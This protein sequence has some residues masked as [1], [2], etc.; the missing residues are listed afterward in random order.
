MS[1]LNF[2]VLRT[3][4]LTIQLKELSL[5]ESIAVAGMPVHL[6]EAIA[7]AFLR[8]AASSVKGEQDPAKWTV[9]ERTFAVCHYLACVR[10]DGP[11]FSLGDNSKYSDYF[12]GE[13]DISQAVRLVPVGEIGGDA[14]NVRHLTG[15]MAESIERIAGLVDGI[16]GR[17][18]WMLGQMAAQLVRDGE[19]TPLPED[20]EGEFDDWLATR[21]KIMAGFPS[22]EFELMV[23]AFGEGRDKLHHL[24]R[25]HY[26]DS[27]L[28]AMPKEGA[29]AGLPPA[30]F[31]V[32]S[33][34]ASIVLQLV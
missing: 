8:T 4:R 30:R 6:N 34:L 14:W 29:A 25:M 20:G 13:S 26:D 32:R 3:K 10:D 31:P 22:S 33:G 16:G 21:M 27:G 12:D 18:H 28:L 5:G 9:Q 17:L 15:G 11:D 7:T 1:H 2:P 19:E 24:F 23:Y